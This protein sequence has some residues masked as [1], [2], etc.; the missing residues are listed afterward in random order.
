MF[1]INVHRQEVIAADGSKVVQYKSYNNLRYGTNIFHKKIEFDVPF[2]NDEYMVF[3][4]T[5]GNGEFVFG[6]DKGDIQE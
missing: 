6:F 2:V 1:S 3:F 4:D 5:Y